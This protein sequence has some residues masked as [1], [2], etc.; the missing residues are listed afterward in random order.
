GVGYS[1]G[2]EDFDPNSTTDRSARL[3]GNCSTAYEKDSGRK[4]RVKSGDCSGVCNVPD[5]ITGTANLDTLQLATN[6]PTHLVDNGSAIEELDTVVSRPGN[7]VTVGETTASPSKKNSNVATNKRSVVGHGPCGIEAA[8]NCT[9]A[10]LRINVRP[11]TENNR[12]LGEGKG[13]GCRLHRID[14]GLCLRR[15]RHA[16]TQRHG[17]RGNGKCDARRATQQTR[18]NGAACGAAAVVRHR[19]GE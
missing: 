17:D 18:A 12:V 7:G 10:G 6:R 9:G 13:K 4:G 16:N 3:V 2:G 14:R 19:G 5:V 15:A 11:S 8:I 1:A